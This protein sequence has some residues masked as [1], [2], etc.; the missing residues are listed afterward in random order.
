MLAS[1]IGSFLTN[2][3]AVA[4]WLGWLGKGILE[5]GNDG[6]KIAVPQSGGQVEIK[7]ARTTANRSRCL[8]LAQLPC[9]EQL[10]RG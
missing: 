6:A 8:M 3:E 4:V 5:S 1:K 9:I 7:S 2:V 10:A